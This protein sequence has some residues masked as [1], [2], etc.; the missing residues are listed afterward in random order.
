MERNLVS[1][2]CYAKIEIPAIIYLI[3]TK[4]KKGVSQTPKKPIDTHTSMIL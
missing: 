2:Q 4:P 1:S 3:Q